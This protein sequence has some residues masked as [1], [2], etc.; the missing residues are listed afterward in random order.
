MPLT[1]RHI[2]I[3][4]NRT[5]YCTTLATKGF[6]LIEEITNKYYFMITF[7]SQ[8]MFETTTIRDHTDLALIG[9]GS[10]CKV[11]MFPQSRWERFDEW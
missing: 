1:I 6:Q 8:L 2:R 7:A 9:M 11:Y 5:L 3:I 10:G 4:G